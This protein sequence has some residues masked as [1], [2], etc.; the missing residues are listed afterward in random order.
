MK[1]TGFDVPLAGQGLA[2]LVPCLVAF[3]M[4]SLL[5]GMRKEGEE[6]RYPLNA[7]AAC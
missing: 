1:D 2:P 6:D 3:M 5:E 4:G 7:C